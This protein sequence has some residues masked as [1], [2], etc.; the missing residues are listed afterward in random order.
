MAEATLEKP[1]IRAE[2]YSMGLTVWRTLGRPSRSIPSF[3]T[4]RRRGVDPSRL[5]R[6]TPNLAIWEMRTSTSA[7]AKP[8][9]Q[10]TSAQI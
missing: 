10:K 3:Q 7:R 9:R 5:R 8:H 4:W 2:G 6:W 1:P